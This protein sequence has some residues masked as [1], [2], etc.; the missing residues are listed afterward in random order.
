MDSIFIEIT[1]T[2]NC[3]CNCQYCFEGHKIHKPRNLD[4]ENRQLELLLDACE[5]FDT[6]KYD[7]FNIS[8][9]GGEPFLNTEFMFKI[10][11]ETYKYDYVRY[12][13]YSNGILIDE[14]KKLTNLEFFD[15]IRDRFHIQLSYDGEPHHTLKR[16]KTGEQV[17]QTARFLQEQNISFSF[18]S[19]LSYDMIQYL[20]EIWDSY[21]QLYIEF[22][23]S[24]LYFPTLDTAATPPKN[25]FDIWKKTIIEVAKKE[26]DFIT[27]YGNALWSWFSNGRKMNCKLENSIHLHNDGN[28]YV[29]HGCPYLDNKDRFIR[30]DIFEIK[31]LFDVVNEQFKMDLNEKCSNCEAT[32]CSACHVTQLKDTDDLYN[33]WS[34]C[35]SNDENKC[36]YYK[37]FGYISKL[38]HFALF[39]KRGIFNLK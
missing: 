18:K 16:G 17:L 20:P 29:C 10:I 39:K 26:Y 28:I 8:F 31:N 33:D 24:A 11:S 30:Q 1:L 14:Y 27:E 12:H 6:N 34:N 9:W 32:H 15:S 25:C 36:K 23:D 3:N 7:R 13:C 38:L 2:D 4:I 5:K 19:T 37:Y 22:G 21:K 35:R